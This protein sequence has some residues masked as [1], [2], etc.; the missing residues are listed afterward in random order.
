[1]HRFPCRKFEL[2]QFRF[3][4]HFSE[5]QLGQSAPVIAHFCYMFYLRQ[6]IPELN[7]LHA[8]KHN[9]QDE[10]L[11]LILGSCCENCWQKDGPDGELR[12][13]QVQQSFS[14]NWRPT[15]TAKKSKTRRHKL[16]QI[17]HSFQKLKYILLWVSDQPPLK[18]HVTKSA[19][20]SDL[21]SFWR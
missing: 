17:N 13:V 3:N 15:F 9:G 20:V 16:S 7:Q 10:C 4:M 21:D 11:C 6:E 5:N 2:H 8:Y 1:M 12:T 14:P 19:G 18:N